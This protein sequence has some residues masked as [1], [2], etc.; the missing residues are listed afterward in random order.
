MTQW[1]Y[2]PDGL[3][4]DESKYLVGK[5]REKFPSAYV[6]KG[7]WEHF[8]PEKGSLYVAIVTVLEHCARFLTGSFNS[9]LF[10]MIFSCCLP[11][12]HGSQVIL[13][14]VFW[15]SLVK[16]QSLTVFWGFRNKF[17][18]LM[19]TKNTTNLWQTVFHINDDLFHV[20]LIHK[21]HWSLVVPSVTIWG[22]KSWV[23]QAY[24]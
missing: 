9:G 5:C 22:R 17:V 13:L 20:P 12:H 10:K 6:T 14:P 11:S 4:V 19:V 8:S 2:V 1:S 16:Q 15:T 24:F 18:L 23:R 21:S 7:L 3:K